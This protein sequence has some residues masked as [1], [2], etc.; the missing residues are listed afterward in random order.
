MT[1][2]V[3]IDGE[4]RGPFEASTVV[5]MIGRG[6]VNAETLVWTAGFEDWTRAIDV[7]DF[8]E[9]FDGVASPSQPLRYGAEI[10]E[11][12]YDGATGRLKFGRV[13]SDAF[14]G[15]SAQPGNTLLIMLAYAGL[16][17]AVSTPYFALVAPKVQVLAE[18]PDQF[19][20]TV[21]GVTDLAAYLFMTVCGIALFGGLCAT[22][23]SL[24]RGGDVSI[25]TLFSGIPRLLPLIGYAILYMVLFS[26]GSL[27]LLLPGIFVG[28]AMMLGMFIIMD[29]HAGAF[30]A[31]KGSF[32]AVLRLGWFRVFG[33]LLL[34]FVAIFAVFLGIGIIAGIWFAAQGGFTGEAAADSVAVTQSI[35][36][37][38]VQMVINSIFGVVFVAIFAAAYE[39]GVPHLDAP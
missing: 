6:E 22:M 19:D 11:D 15:L 25:G 23:L 5:Q 3:L 27:L 31:T 7:P 37:Y 28:V 21:F 8:S 30:A 32:R 35:T 1:W 10:T 38:A 2:H 39:Q 14:R 29:R 9:N 4:Q 12:A 13:F 20:I 17:V 24:V 16:A 26:I 18:A 34:L 36:F 33:L